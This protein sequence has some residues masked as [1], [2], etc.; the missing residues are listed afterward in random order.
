MGFPF[1]TM[2]LCAVTIG[3]NRRK[4][5]FSRI[6][7]HP[8][9]TMECLFGIRGRDFCVLAADTLSARSIVVMK[10]DECKWR[11]LT[12]TCGMVFQGEPGDAISL[13]DYLQA[14][15]RLYGVRNDGLELSPHACAHFV[16]HTLSDGLRSGSGA[17]QVN[18]LVGGVVPNAESAASVGELYWIDYLGSMVP[19]PF[20]CQGYGSYFCMG[21]LDRYYRSDLT[22]D[23]AIALLKRCLHELK[24]RFVANL[25]AFTVRVYR[26]DGEVQELTIVPA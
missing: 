5:Q 24:V 16:R 18:L 20:A 9:P 22:A 7:S 23:D 11:S 15:I 21:L 6:S 4:N 1:I 19:L 10:A 26:A 25:P 17:Q 13:A 3:I 2:A 14:N 8:L 12:P